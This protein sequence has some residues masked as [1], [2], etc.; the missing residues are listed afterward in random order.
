[1]NQKKER[2]SVI[3]LG[4]SGTIGKNGV[5]HS[6]VQDLLANFTP[7]LQAFHHKVF[8]V[9]GGTRVREAQDAEAAKNPSV[10]DKRK[11]EIGIEILEEHAD[12]LAEIVKGLG[13]SVATIPRNTEDLHK[14]IHSL[15]DEAVVVSGLQPGQ[16]TDTG[17]I[18][19]AELFRRICES[20]A[21]AVILSN[22]LTIFTADPNHP[23]YAQTARPIKKANVRRLVEDGVLLSG[24]DKWKPGMSIPIDPVA[25]ALLCENPIERL[26][27]T[28]V[29]NT[30]DV[31]RFL[32]Q[33][34][35]AYGTSLV[36][37]EIETEYHSVT[38]A[39]E[40]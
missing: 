25:V 33:E 38:Q 23:D 13:Y 32:R 21:W 28:K 3:K 37:E 8:V 12:Q 27:F 4:G 34:D 20:E 16:S 40:A 39:S 5:E 17:A 15:Q 1:M 35:T 24:K 14:L 26:Y 18:Y 10:T 36:N 30:A 9:G 11:D 2:V 7:E 31:K 22:V 19:T 6:A 29:N